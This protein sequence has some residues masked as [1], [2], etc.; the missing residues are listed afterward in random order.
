MT[1]ADRK[2]SQREAQRRWRAN[3]RDKVAEQSRRWRERHKEAQAEAEEIRRDRNKGAR[4]AYQRDWRARNAE[5]VKAYNRAYLAT[6][7]G[8]ETQRQWRLNNPEKVRE[9]KRRWEAANP[10]KVR[11]KMRRYHEKR[12]GGRSAKQALADTLGMRLNSNA[13]YGA[14]NE[15]VPRGLPADIRD[16][17]ISLIVLAVLEG[18]LRPDEIATRSREVVRAHYREFSDFTLS[19]DAVIPGTDGLRMIDTL[20]SHHPE[21]NPYHDPV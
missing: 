8:Q 9:A 16:D 1:D 6:E 14:A 12:M 20:K 7:A 10:E 21:G 4:N 13:I 5:H 2:A 15:A 3:N 11:E 19:L 18:E 17:I